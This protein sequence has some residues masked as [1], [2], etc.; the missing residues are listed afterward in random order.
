MEAKITLDTIN[1]VTIDVFNAINNGHRSFDDIVKHTS[2]SEQTIK[3]CLEDCISQQL[4]CQ[5]KN[6][7]EYP[8]KFGKD[9]YVVLEGNILLPCSV[10]KIPERNIMYVTR[11]NWY[12]FPLDFDVRR[13]IW[14]IKFVDGNKSTL[15]ELIRTSILKERKS[16]IQHLPEYDNLKNKIAPWSNDIG[17]LITAVGEEATSVNMIFRIRF[18]N[19]FGS[20]YNGFTV[21]SVINTKNFLEELQKPADQ[22]DFSRIEINRIFEVEDFIFVKNEIPIAIEG[23][24]LQYF[25]LTGIRNGY[26]LTYYQFDANT[27][28]TKKLEV[29]TYDNLEEVRQRFVHAFEHFA[30][31]ILAKSDIFVNLE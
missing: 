30:G 18:D 12:E 7:Y 6:G 22:K 15:S 3:H 26:E 16:K 31:Q 9:D 14:N 28:Q 21:Q 4:I 2:H 27:Q 20:V 17:L 1:T 8:I 10:I 5:T 19:A 13:I 24:K 25:K 23:N 11:G 29:V